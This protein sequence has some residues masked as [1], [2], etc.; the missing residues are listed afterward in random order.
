MQLH[1]Q[2]V[3]NDEMDEVELLHEM[4][5]QQLKVHHTILQIL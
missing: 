3:L 2:L 1:E 4:D 5:E